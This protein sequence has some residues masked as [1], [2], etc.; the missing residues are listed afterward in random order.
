MPAP[1]LPKAERAS[2]TVG[3]PVSVPCVPCRQNT[4]DKIPV[5]MTTARIISKK[6]SPL[7]IRAPT[8]M[9]GTQME[10]PAQMKEVFHQPW[11]SLWGTGWNASSSNSVFFSVCSCMDNCLPFLKN[12]GLICALH[13]L[14]RDWFQ[15]RRCAMMRTLLI[16]ISRLQNFGFL[17]RACVKRQA[18]REPGFRDPHRHHHHRISGDGR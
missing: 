13:H 14:R 8:M 16:S 1:S 6:D 4:R 9:V 15:H 17:E 7:I 11:R 18:H 10:L 5:P 2:T 12:N 3:R